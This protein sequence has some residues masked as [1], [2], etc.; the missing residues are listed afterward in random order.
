MNRNAVQKR[1]EELFRDF[2]GEPRPGARVALSRVRQEG[3]LYEAF[4]LGLVAREL[5]NNENLQLRLV[6]GNYLA[7][8]SSPGP[9]NNSY[10]YVEVFRQQNHVANIWTDVEFTSL[11]CVMRNREGNPSNGEYHELDILMVDPDANPRPLPHEIW[12][13][14]ECKDTSY[15]KSLLKEILGIRRELSLLQDDKPT[16]FTT[17]PR[18][19]VPADPP[20]C[21]LVYSTDHKVS[22]YSEPGTV[23][24]IDFNCE[25]F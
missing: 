17:W 25:T 2:L 6:G 4:V 12:L 18:R 5:V 9:I 20:S 14:V 23:F 10:P 1:I 3:K 19:S 11:S 16:R 8:K 22:S 21:V 15:S 13:G 7:L 24:G